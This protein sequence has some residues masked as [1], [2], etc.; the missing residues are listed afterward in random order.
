MLI[1][2]THRPWLWRSIVILAVCA[3]VY[4]PYNHYTLGGARGGTVIGI[5]YGSLG[6]GFMIFA[7]LLSLRKRFPV[8]RMGR[9]S[10]WMRGHLWLGLLSYPIILFHSAF[11]FGKGTLTWWM[12]LL[13]TIVIVSGL[14]GAAIQH[15]L[16]KMMTRQ[17]PYETI[18]AEIPRIRGQLLDE[19]DVK[20]AEITGITMN[21]SVIAAAAGNAGGVIV[22]TVQMEEQVRDELTRFYS[23]D[24]RPYL[25]LE[26]GKGQAIA[27]RSLSAAMF[28]NVR[29]RLPEVVHPVI[30]D[31]E[32]I[33][34]EKRQLDRQLNLH[35]VLHAWLL[36][37]LPLSFAL[38]LMGAVHAVVALRY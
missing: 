29:T 28:I 4:V 10:S 15:Y 16:P 21:Q 9:T 24:L 13:F 12:M 5:I 37:H 23:N 22:T 33:C 25:E 32:S 27:D 36:I 6:F 26:G 17:V 8:W 1:D 11:S 19:A 30:S 2:Q 35:R 7:G 31:L 38:L 34:E 3:A 14:I 20:V 18:Y